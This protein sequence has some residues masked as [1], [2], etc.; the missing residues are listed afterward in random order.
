MGEFIYNHDVGLARNN[1]VNVHLLEHH[2][3]VRNIA[4]RN[5]LEVA[6]PLLGLTPAMGFDETQNHIH[7]PL[8]ELMRLLEHPVCFAYSRGGADVN[9]EPTLLTLGNEIE[10][11]FG[12]DSL[13]IVHSGSGRTTMTSCDAIEGEV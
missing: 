11:S 9:F 13:V 10:E 3:T 8:A 4:A 1:R 7:S 5:H 2:A 12:L 6:D